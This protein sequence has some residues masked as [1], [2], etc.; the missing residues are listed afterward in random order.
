MNKKLLTLAVAAAVAAPTAALAEA[1]LYG[2]LHQSIDYVDITNAY[3]PDVVEYDYNAV[4]FRASEETEPGE[5]LY[6]PG[7]TPEPVPF[8]NATQ[9][10]FDLV[11]ADK[12]GVDQTVTLQP[13]Q[14][15]S[16]REGF[17]TDPTTL[18][19]GIYEGKV[20]GVRRLIAVDA[21]G[22]P[23]ADGPTQDFS[24][25]GI[26]AR[27][28]RNYTTVNPLTGIGGS[29]NDRANRLGVKGSEDLGNGLKAIY[30]V[31][32]GLNIADGS[33]ISYR[34]SFAGIAGDFGTV[35]V[36][37]HDTP[38]KISSGKLDLFSDTMADYNGTVGFHDVRAPRAVAYISPSFSGV[39]FAAATIAGGATG[40]DGNVNDDSLASGYSLALIYKNGPFYGSAAY[41]VMGNEMFMD[42]ETSLLGENCVDDDGNQA[43][44][45]DFIGDDFSKWRIGLGLLDW[46]GFTLTAIYEQQDDLP[47]GQQYETVGFIDPNGNVTFDTQTGI[48]SQELWQVQAGYSFG[49][50]MVKAMYGAVDRDEGS[51]SAFN[52]TRQTLALNSI[53][54]DLGGDREAWAIGFDHNFSKRTKVY[55]LYTDVSDD[56][57]DD[58]RVE[59]AEWSGFSLGLIHSF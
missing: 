5:F 58:P 27:N 53:R 48:S 40:D 57:S 31:E 49:N 46:N 8:V 55:A 41:E 44:S 52:Q 37:R 38:M 14:S 22:N 24:G 28:W 54:E 39:S 4:Q 59:G 47:A 20:D 36:G 26:S 34:N 50:N 35:L 10:P 9:A 16:L 21:N 11:Y 19:A 17:T 1:V 32:F 6:Y 3:S 42:T 18:P 43:L 23:I 25:W 13:G 33:S 45:C 30:Q 29:V 12:D 15:F 56:L 2:K 7:S 51:K